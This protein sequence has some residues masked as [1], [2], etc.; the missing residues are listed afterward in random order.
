MNDAADLV[1]R[2]AEHRTLGGAPRAELE[3]LVAHGA[4]YNFEPGDLLERLPHLYESLGVMLSGHFAI[5]VDHGAG[6]HKVMEW[7]GGDVSGYLPY[8]RMNKAIGTM[9]IDVPGDVLVV[10]SRHFPELI[11]ECPDVTTR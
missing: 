9:V 6:P 5:H 10:H 8:S 11:R 4:H 1:A 7:G 3:W 2:L